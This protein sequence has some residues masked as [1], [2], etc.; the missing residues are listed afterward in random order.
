MRVSLICLPVIKSIPRCEDISSQ[1]YYNLVV[2]RPNSRI[3]IYRRYRCTRSSSASQNDY[4]LVELK[5]EKLCANDEYR[6]QWLWWGPGQQRTTWRQ[7]PRG[8]CSSSC[9]TYK[10]VFTSQISVH[11]YSHG[12][13]RHT[14][15]I[16][17]LFCLLFTISWAIKWKCVHSSKD[18]VSRLQT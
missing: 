10:L 8:V 17:N 16:F 4:R 15:F 11:T 6:L 7:E 3:Q 14:L 18:K 13:E 9:T 5:A 1:V 12:N 2:E